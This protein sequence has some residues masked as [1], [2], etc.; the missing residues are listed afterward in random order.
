MG[1][2]EAVLEAVGSAGVFGDVA[3]DGADGLGAGVGRVEEAV[4]GDGGGDV[5]V[6]DA[7]L[8]GDLLVG[9]V[10]VEDAVH[11]GEADDDGAGGGKRSAAES[12]AGSAG[13]EGDVVLRADADDGLDL[14]GAARED[15]GGGRDA[16]GGEAVALVGLEL[17]G[18]GDE[19]GLARVGVGAGV[20]GGAEIVEDGGGQHIAR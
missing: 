20:E 13:D 1:G 15:D 16:E 11:A 17:V 4:W 6:D 9:E 2:G 7:G 3:A 5:G 10:D 8:D 12:G 14:L 19:A 18:R